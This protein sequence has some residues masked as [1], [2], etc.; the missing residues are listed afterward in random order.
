MHVG[1]LTQQV[2]Y[3]RFQSDEGMYVQISL[4]PR[5]LPD[6]YLIA[7]ENS[8]Q[9]HYKIWELDFIQKYCMAGNIDSL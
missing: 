6:F 5:L 4:I 3:Y 8:L 1:S 9:L 2:F 7:A